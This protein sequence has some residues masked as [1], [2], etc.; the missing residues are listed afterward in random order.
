[1]ALDMISASKT[2]TGEAHEIYR[3]LCIKLNMDADILEVAWRAYRATSP[4]P[5]RA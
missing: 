3:I 5:T 1:M 4:S 2:K